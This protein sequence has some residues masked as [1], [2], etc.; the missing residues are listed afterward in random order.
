MIHDTNSVKCGEVTINWYI[1]FRISLFVCFPF[2]YICN[3]HIIKC[4]FGN[5]YHILQLSAHTFER[6]TLDIMYFML[7]LQ[8]NPVI[9]CSFDNLNFLLYK[10]FFFK[11]AM[12]KIFCHA[13]CILHTV[14][15][16][17]FICHRHYICINKLYLSNINL[18]H[19]RN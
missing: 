3:D 4:T 18:H 16:H 2:S 15:F 14:Q 5:F 8:I 7:F 12:F 1:I 17:N 19:I 10:D 11:N 6:K 9:L 13:T